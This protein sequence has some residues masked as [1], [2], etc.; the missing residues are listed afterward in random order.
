M[1]ELKDTHKLETNRRTDGQKGGRA[2]D[3]GTVQADEQ[4]S[5]SLV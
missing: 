1:N 3:G 2:E 5:L 4:T